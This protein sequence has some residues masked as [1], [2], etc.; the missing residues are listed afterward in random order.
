MNVFKYTIIRETSQFVLSLIT[1]LFLFIVETFNDDIS[2]GI[3]TEGY[4]TILI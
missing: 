2:I 4:G 3:L 1:T